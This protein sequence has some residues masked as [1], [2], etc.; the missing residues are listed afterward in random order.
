[1]EP[2]SI[3]KYN[4]VD[5][6]EMIELVVTSFESKLCYRLRLKPNEIKDILQLT[7]NIRACDAGYL[8]YVAKMENEV[9]GVMLIQHGII[10]KEKKKVPIF[11]LFRRYGLFNILFL[12]FKIS[13]LE[14]YKPD[15][16]YIEHIAVDASVRGRG[17][18][19]MLLA[20]GQEDLKKMG[21]SS[22]SLAVAKGNPAK[23]LYDREGFQDIIYKKTPFQGYFIGVKEW[24][25]MEKRLHE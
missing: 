9:V 5:F 20:K 7:W 19:E 4:D 8:H 14:I 13:I 10:Q 16:A 18:G 15:G 11:P 21:Y 24:I 25:F 1:M 3:E 22:L 23:H 17:I 12:I 6:N 2:I